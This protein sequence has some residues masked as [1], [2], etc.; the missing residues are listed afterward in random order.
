[1]VFQKGNKLSKDRAPWNKG[2]KMS[3][4]S[5]AKRIETMKKNNGWGWMYG[6]K[7]SNETKTKMSIS[8]KNRK[9]HEWTKE[10]RMKL[11][12]TL[13]GK[14]AWNKG[15]LC[16][17]HNEKW[18][19][20]QKKRL[21]EKYRIMRVFK[22][23]DKSIKKKRL[24][25]WNK[26]LTKEIHPSIMSISKHKLGNS[27]N[28]GKIHNEVW[29]N[30][31]SKAIKEFYKTEQGKRAK[32]KISKIIKESRKKQIFPLKDTSIEI[33]IQNFLKQLGIEFFTHQYIKEIEHGYQCDILIPSMNLIVEC[34]GNYWHKYPIRRDI[35]NVRTKELIEKGFRVLRLWE[36]EINDMDLNK[37]R[38]VIFK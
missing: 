6:R 19:E 9:P 2:K 29:L 1:M 23:L 21:D 13:K 28:K 20:N 38:E 3:I 22:L 25:S 31:N 15:I 17:P 36:S 8:H 16:G 30:N 27:W 5:I 11:S 32:E 24:T 10:S 26:G 7:L 14:E 12:N 35:D 34:D 4:E 33:K 37:F 18:K